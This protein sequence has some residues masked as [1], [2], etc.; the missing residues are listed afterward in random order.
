MPE[1]DPYDKDQ[2]DSIIPHESDEFNSDEQP[3]QSDENINSDGEQQ[4]QDQNSQHDQTVVY[5]ENELELQE[6]IVDDLY[7]FELLAVPMFVRMTPKTFYNIVQNTP[8]QTVS[9]NLIPS[10]SKLYIVKTTYELEVREGFLVLPLQIN[11]L[12]INENN[13][14]AVLYFDAVDSKMKC[15]TKPNNVEIIGNLVGFQVEFDQAVNCTMFNFK[16][17]NQTESQMVSEY[18]V[19][20]DTIN[21]IESIFETNNQMT[22]TIRVAGFNNLNYNTSD[23]RTL[24]IKVKNKLSF[25]VYSVLEVLQ[26]PTNIILNKHYFNYVAYIISVINDF[27][28]MNDKEFIEMF[29]LE[30]A[31]QDEVLK[32]ISWSQISATIKNGINIGTSIKNLIDEI[33]PKI[34]DTFKN[35][36]AMFKKNKEDNVKVVVALPENVEPEKQITTNA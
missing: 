14:A 13:T 12:S 22:Q 33:G 24:I 7:T 34:S 15:L 36:K 32:S 5:N 30:S 25:R 10:F 35:I 9:I 4:Q 2:P 31:F 16:N 28:F 3:E 11:L 23:S 6:M 29:N 8:I 17:N 27:L 18:D 21:E 1:N 26:Q 19:E 20:P